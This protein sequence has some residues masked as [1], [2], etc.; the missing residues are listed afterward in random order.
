M[1]VS[2]SNMLLCRA[3]AYSCMLLHGNR[4]M[5]MQCLVAVSCTCV[6][7]VHCCNSHIC[8]ASVCC[9][10]EACRFQVGHGSLHALSA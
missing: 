1:V 7:G 3:A 2:Y 4:A 5:E 10:F 6:H 8:L 9:F